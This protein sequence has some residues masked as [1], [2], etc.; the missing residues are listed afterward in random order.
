MSGLIKEIT[1]TANP[2]IKEI[3]ALAMKKNR[4]ASNTFIAEG[5]KLVT[6]AVE[7][8]WDIR[9][10]VHGRRLEDDL[11]ARVEALAAKVHA[12]GGN[13]L[14]VSEKV[15]G[16]ISKRDNPQ[17][18]LA[19]IEQNWMP[20]DEVK[21]SRSGLWV[22]LDRVRDPGNLGTIIRT[23]DAAGADGVLLI[24]A[25]TDPFALEAVRATMGSIFHLPLA[26]ASNEQFLKWRSN[27]PGIVV[28]THLSGAVDH[29]TIDYQD[30]PVMIL[31][32]NEQQ[33]LPDMLARECDHLALIAMDGAADSLNLAIAT[34]IMLFEAR[35]HA[36]ILEPL[37]D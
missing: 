26:R 24:G 3:R 12:R 10:L 22:A 18:V 11:A 6:D 15:L 9:T 21:P 36:L 29:R 23:A 30:K 35:R 14:Q 8:G 27:W 34:G 2:L 20:L 5:L 17:I 25:T 31:M 4:D 7:R 33:G 19:V 1:S 37:N 32:G 28:G 13:V 16:A